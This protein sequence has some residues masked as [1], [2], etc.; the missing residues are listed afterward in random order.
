[1]QQVYLT[2]LASMTIET[3][4]AFTIPTEAAVETSEEGGPRKARQA[5]PTYRM[6]KMSEFKNKE[7]QIED[8]IALV[9]EKRDRTV[10]YDR[11]YLYDVY[12]DD[13][14]DDGFQPGMTIY[15]GGTVQADDDGEKFYP[16]AVNDLGYS[17]LYSGENFQAVVDLAYRQKP[18]ASIEEVVRCLNHYAQ[19]DDFQ[20]LH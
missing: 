18:T 20:D 10:G 13:S 16:A 17:F 15:V 3:N 2:S 5:E 8:F 14:D 7:Y 9:R 6:S 12:R 19:Y 11:A 4:M 1:M